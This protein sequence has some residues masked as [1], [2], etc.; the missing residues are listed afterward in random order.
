[1][2]GSEIIVADPDLVHV[3][4][5]DMSESVKR[6]QARATC[7]DADGE[8]GSTNA[9]TCPSGY[10]S[11]GANASEPHATRAQ[12]V[13][14]TQQHAAMNPSVSYHINIGFCNVFALGLL[15]KVQ[16]GQTKQ[17]SFANEKS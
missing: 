7:G 6:W 12:Q 1:M 16:T 3:G 5:R 8:G 10:V 17:D 13:P 4:N 15:V 11:H 14:R 9:V 2:G